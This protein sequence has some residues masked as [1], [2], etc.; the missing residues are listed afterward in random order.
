MTYTC[1]QVKIYDIK[2][3][4]LVRNWFKAI[5]M[6]SK[7]TQK[8]IAK[9]SGVSRTTITEIENGNSN[10]S[11]EKAKKIAAIL[12]FDWTKFFD[13]DENFKETG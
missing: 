6:S 13:D 5:R 8:Q 12:D 4:V 1:K 11:V 2:G 9:L 7:M 10:P 3:V